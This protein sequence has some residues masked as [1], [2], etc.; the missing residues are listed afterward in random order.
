MYQHR[1]REQQQQRRQR[2]IATSRRMRSRAGKGAGSDDDLLYSFPAPATAA[3]QPITPS[4]SGGKQSSSFLSRFAV[5]K[6]KFCQNCTLYLG[7]AVL[8]ID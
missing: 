4:T 5:F 8:P 6:L 7:Q 1:R 2:M 3:K